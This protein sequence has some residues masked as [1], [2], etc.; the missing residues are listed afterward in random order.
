MIGNKC[1]CGL[2]PVPR[3][4]DVVGSSDRKIDWSAG[5]GDTASAAYEPNLFL[6]DPL[7]KQAL[8]GPDRLGPGTGMYADEVGKESLTAALAAKARSETPP[9]PE[10]HDV[11]CGA[12][13]DNL[14]AVW[15]SPGNEQH[16][17]RFHVVVNEAVKQPAEQSLRALASGTGQ[18]ERVRLDEVELGR[19]AVRMG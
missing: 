3:V 7:F 6:A 14:S 9:L 11:L 2:V 5:R 13:G 16:M 12:N 19:G 8:A 10:I 17:L 4:A 1:G 15:R 18:Q